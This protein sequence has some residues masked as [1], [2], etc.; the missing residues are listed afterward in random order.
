M[1]ASALA[2]P[3][4]DGDT[5]V[6]R[7]QQRVGSRLERTTTLSL[8]PP[9]ASR[10]PIIQTDGL[11][12]TFRTG[13]LRTSRVALSGVSLRIEPGEIFGLLGGN[14]AGKTTLLKL[15]LG[16]LHPTNG[17]GETFGLPLGSADARRRIGYLP[18]T[19]SFPDALTPHETLHYTADL[20]GMSSK[21]A[22]AA[23]GRAIERTG[24]GSHQH[25]RH[26][27]LSKG[28]VQRVALAQAILSEPRLLILDEP[29]SGLD[30]V[31]RSEVRDLIAELSRDG[32]TILFSSHILPD[33]QSLCGRVALLSHGQLLSAGHPDEIVDSADDIVEITLARATVSGP[34][35][36]DV[37][38]D[39]G[40]DIAVRTGGSVMITVPRAQLSA[41]L[42]LTLAAGCEVTTVL[43]RGRALANAL[44]DA[45]PAPAV[46]HRWH[47]R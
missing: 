45:Q 20:H 32:V 26:R 15:L 47:A 22:R 36:R 25:A 34:A 9:Q 24:I 16:L 44:R 42:R 38:V 33:V 21:S 12:K 5:R 6:A 14:G 39:V 3:I 37:L 30:P 29:M 43:P 8:V 23:V 1:I 2:V 40:A 41:A 17:A 7:D 10:Q 13:L 31:G 27:T 46:P 18:E 19:P 35:L 28:L 11:S 4:D